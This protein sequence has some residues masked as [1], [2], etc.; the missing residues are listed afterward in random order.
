MGEPLGKMNVD[1][2]MIAEPA[3]YNTRHRRQVQSN[4]S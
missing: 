1:E 3:G 4:A 2:N